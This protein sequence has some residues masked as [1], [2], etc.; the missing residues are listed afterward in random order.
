M[1]EHSSSP[2]YFPHIIQIDA[3]HWRSLDLGALS[4]L[5][6]DRAIPDII[7]YRQLSL[8]INRRRPAETPFV[9]AGQLNMYATLLKVYHHLIE[10][11]AGVQAPDVLA[12]ALRRSGHDPAGDAT[13]VIAGSFVELFPPGGV[14]PAEGR[15][16]L[17]APEASTSRQRLVLRELLLLRLA[18]GNPALASFRELLDDRQ[19]AASAPA[20]PQLIS[21]MEQALSRSPQ[22]PGLEMTL[23]EA[24][25]APILASPDSLSGQVGFIRE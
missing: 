21:H 6:A 24:L 3:Q 11:A 15:Q 20:Y 23:A 8:R 17:H 19:L 25:R 18:A 13:A 1:T 10:E 9:H 16:W 5:I 4:R 12:D 22:L 14:L 2:P 7:F